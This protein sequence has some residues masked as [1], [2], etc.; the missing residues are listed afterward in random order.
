[1]PNDIAHFAIH[2]DDCQRA[3]RFYEAVF[4][5][6]FEPWGPPDFWRV[7]TSPGGIHGALQ[8]RRAPVTGA[9]VT[10][11]E[12]TIAVEDVAVTAAAIEAHGGQLTMEPFEIEQVGD[13]RDVQG[14]RRGTPSARCNIWPARC[15]SRYSDSIR[16]SALTGSRASRPRIT[17]LPRFGAIRWGSLS[18]AANRRI[19]TTTPGQASMRP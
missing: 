16:S 2:A 1:M 14:T 6:A 4:G 10:A 13:S 5:W 19:Q 7:H 12:C 18:P 9:G 15:E 17:P 3:K 8:K 11:F